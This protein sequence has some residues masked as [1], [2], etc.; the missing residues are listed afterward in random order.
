MQIKQATLVPYNFGLANMWNIDLW[1]VKER[2]H[3]GWCS[4]ALLFWVK[5]CTTSQSRDKNH[6]ICSAQS[7]ETGQGLWFGWWLRQT[8][9]ATSLC[10]AGKLPNDWT[11]I[12][13]LSE[14]VSKCAAST[15][16]GSK[17]ASCSLYNF[18]GY[19]TNIAYTWWR[20]CGSYVSVV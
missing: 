15:L 6:W 3:V 20:S 9:P 8:M 16:Y 7:M 5:Q 12:F 17:K 18:L 11:Q 4:T 19:Q 1:M 2:Q 10:K 14:L 13:P